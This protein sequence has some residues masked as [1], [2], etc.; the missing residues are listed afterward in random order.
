MACCT[1]KNI[2]IRC[3]KNQKRYFVCA[4]MQTVRS[5]YSEN[6][7]YLG[8]SLIRGRGKNLG[9]HGLF[10]LQS[11][12]TCTIRPGGTYSN[13]LQTRSPSS[14]LFN[15]PNIFCLYLLIPLNLKDNMLKSTLKIHR[16]NKILHHFFFILINLDMQ[17]F[18]NAMTF[19]F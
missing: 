13:M 18:Q 17:P 1:L 3:T 9:N 19:E 16:I 4:E 6:G 10:S 14:C 15:W 5:Y 11:T 8:L 12:Y 7:L 2:G